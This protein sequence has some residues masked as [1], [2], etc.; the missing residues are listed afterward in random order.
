MTKRRLRKSRRFARSPDQ[1]RTLRQA[2]EIVWMFTVCRRL[3]V[4]VTILAFRH[5]DINL[6]SAFID[7]IGEH[8]ILNPSNGL[9]VCVFPLST[10]PDGLN[11]FVCAIAVRLVNALNFQSCCHNVSFVWNEFH[12]VPHCVCFDACGTAS[13]FR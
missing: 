3:E 1:L 6:M 4:F 8:A 5:D 11:A 9:F 10:S 2:Q 13:T 7:V 12:L